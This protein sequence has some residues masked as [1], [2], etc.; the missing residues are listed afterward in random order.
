MH[1]LEKLNKRLQS[2]SR[3]HAQIRGGL[4]HGDRIRGD[5]IRGHRLHD[6]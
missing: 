5:R 1:S 2:V 3:R 6:S 4:I